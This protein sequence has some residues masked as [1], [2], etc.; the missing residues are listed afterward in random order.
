MILAKIKDFLKLE[1]LVVVIFAILGSAA[2]GWYFR[3]QALEAEKDTFAAKVE[4]LVETNQAAMRNLDVLAGLRERDHQ[5]F[6][7]M[8]QELS[9]IE[10]TYSEMNRSLGELERANEQVRDYMSQ[11]VPSDVIRLRQEQRKAYQ[12]RD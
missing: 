2:V 7:Q 5:F 10:A 8:A 4:Q 6:E 1:V 9:R 3:A 12:G 11:R